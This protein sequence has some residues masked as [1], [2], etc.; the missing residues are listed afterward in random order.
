MAFF[1]SLVEFIE[2]FFL[3]SN[4]DVKMKLD[5]R[6]LEN[7]LKM[8]KPEIYKNGQLTANFGNAFFVLYKETAVIQEIL[9]NTINSDNSQVAHHYMDLLISTGFTGEY[10]Q[11]VANLSYENL[12]ENIIN[13]TNQH[14][15]FEEQAKNLE[16][17]VKFLHTPE[18]KKIEQ[19]LCQIDRLYDIC[20]F[21]F[22]SVIHL[23]DKDFNEISPQPTY[24]NV[25]LEKLEEIL[26]DLYFLVGNY[27]LTSTQA[28]AITVLAEQKND[29]SIN[30]E[31]HDKIM[32]S[33][34]KISSVLKRVLNKT[35]LLSM[36]KIIKKNPDLTLMPGKFN[37]NKIALYTIRLQKRYSANIERIQSEIKDKKI[38][39]DI[40]TLFEGKQIVNL[41]YYNADTNRFLQTAG[42]PSFLWV[43]PAMVLKTFIL[44][45]YTEQLQ[46]LL[47]DIVVEGFFANQN[48]KKDFA[49]KVFTCSESI[50]RIQ[51][52][53]KKF[54]KDG[55]F[56]LAILK[57]LASE[58]HKNADLGKKL[59][60][61]IETINAVIQ[62]LLKKEVKAFKDMYIILET[63][64]SESHKSKTDNIS[65]IKMIFS[66]V[67]NRDSVEILEKQINL[68]NFFL[69]IMKNYVIINSTDKHE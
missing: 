37:P 2:T 3:S 48:Y 9:Q 40:K 19:V 45:F 63:L 43:T 58:S 39:N 7:D 13:A 33:L 29:G 60:K 55:P 41:Q 5:I 59:I 14:K 52:F 68:W 34:K 8:I 21:N 24:S 31:Y 57:N 27:E 35:N 56:D 54:E 42:F 23:F 11:K 67:R 6:K 4:P 16:S 30:G 38:E 18:F 1:Q 49:A 22:M 61:K 36:L 47:D 10:K 28:R 64:V 44:H 32:A 15:A 53:E 46:S 25:D 66:S 26:M 65:N 50:L 17:I 20:R 62:H 51:E 69:E 12:Q